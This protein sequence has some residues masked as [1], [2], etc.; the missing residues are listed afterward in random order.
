MASSPP[1]PIDKALA[2]LDAVAGACRP[3]TLTEI[4][5]STGLALPTVHRVAHQLLERRL[6][7]RYMASRRLLPGPRLA[8]LGMEAV[9]AQMYADKPHTILKALAIE[10]GEFAMISIVVDGEL[11]CIDTASVHRPSPQFFEQGYRAPLHC[12]SVG[13][14]YLSHLPDDD[15]ES[16]L[17]HAHLRAYS[18]ATIT[19]H[20][21]LRRQCR[22]ARRARF[23]SCNEEY[24]RGVVGCSVQIE[25]PGAV[26]FVGLG[27]S[28]PAARVGHDQILRAVPKLF[29]TALKIS[30]ALQRYAS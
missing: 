12:T 27:L 22:E 25:V 11:I 30:L 28:A 20:A 18:P 15:F 16:W 5:A 17:R 14:L 8:R 1:A 9:Q 4:A 29:A 13:K 21:E 24:S 2:I 23:A 6:L 19:D 10:M 7:R 26:G 3:V